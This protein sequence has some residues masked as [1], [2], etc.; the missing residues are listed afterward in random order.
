MA[1]PDPELESLFTSIASRCFNARLDDDIRSALRSAYDAGWEARRERFTMLLTQAVSTADE[2][3]RERDEAERQRDSAARAL[4]KAL[5]EL[6]RLRGE[7]PTYG[8]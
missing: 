1:A 3:T 6:D 8:D 5:A 4:A 7:E 2:R